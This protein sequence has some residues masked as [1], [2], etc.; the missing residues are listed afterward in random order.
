MTCCKWLLLAIILIILVDIILV[1]SLVWS[2]VDIVIHLNLRSH[3]VLSGNPFNPTKGELRGRSGVIELAFARV[4]ESLMASVSI[5]VNKYIWV[6]DG[7]ILF[8]GI[9][10]VSGLVSD[11]LIQGYWYYEKY[12]YK[13]SG[14]FYQTFNSWASII[15]AS[16]WYLLPRP[17]SW[18]WYTW[19]VKTDT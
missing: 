2:V 5:F 18:S 17:I 9:C 16:H 8:F 14:C 13:I 6:I 10:N 4:P 7:S 15:P 19:L 1:V 11:V 12:V 3:S